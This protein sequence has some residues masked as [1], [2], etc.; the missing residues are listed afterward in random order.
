MSGVEDEHEG[1]HDEGVFGESTRR[2]GRWWVIATVPVVLVAGAFVEGRDA[3][4]F[5]WAIVSGLYTTPGLVVTALLIRRVDRADRL[6]WQLWLAALAWAYG[7][8]LTLQASVLAGVRIPLWW[9]TGAMGVV[10][11][12]F[13]IPLVMMLR[14]RSGGRAI[15]LDV[16]EM[17]MVLT[18]LL[19]PAT[20]LVIE[21]IAETEEAW[22]VVPAALAGT[23][24]FSAFT[25]AIVL[26]VR[27]RPGRR[28]V[29]GL[30]IAAALAGAVTA[31]AN[32]AQGLS[33]FTLPSGPLLALQAIS[34]GLV[35]LVPLHVPRV[36]PQGLDRL[37]P[38]RRARS[39]RFVAVVSL[40][41]LPVLAI[42]MLLLRHD[43]PWAVPY[44]FSLAALLLLLSTL[45]HLLALG[46]T[47]RLYA[48]V[49]RAAQQ[50]RTLLADVMRSAEED[51]HRVAAQLHE[52]AAS[53]Y[54]TFVAFIQAT[55]DDDGP[56]TDDRSAGIR[57]DLLRQTEDLRRLMLAIK[58]L[59][60]NAIGPRN[61]EA[62]LRA[63]LDSLYG[64]ATPPALA[65]DIRGTRPL[66]WITETVLLRIVQ[67]ALQNI[68][69]HARAKHVAVA[70]EAVEGGLRLEVVDDGVGFA[71]ERVLVL[72]GIATM[73]S[74]ASFL[75]GTV[76]IDSAP[77]HG[78]RV[79][80]TLS[81]SS[82]I[83]SS[84]IAPSP[85]GASRMSPT[86]APDL[87]PED[88]VD[89]PGH[90]PHLRVI[91]GGVRDVRPREV[92]HVER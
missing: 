79:T 63:H 87:V 45:R 72:S 51:R 24:L 71:P 41:A 46:E 82:P 6:F 88:A 73:R 9:S 57:H 23:C 3:Y 39:G 29:E 42:E 11:L 33:S 77:G 65:V 74:F 84:P 59:E 22:W 40:V 92:S 52:R 78:T 49:E 31:A 16:V 68:W 60:A 10:I 61:L 18:S 43:I 1:S 67:E 69:S 85:I 4:L 8:G 53:S 83:A 56:S 38:Q 64:D 12:L 15:V 48:E 70:I 32:V 58:P 26:F 27:L 55:R 47:K 2:A 36:S 44:A 76:D 37:P 28:V 7:M 86:P 50:R 13:T 81:A 19:A 17:A 54:A 20:L 25:W 91:A 89:P 90:R 30:G 62:P 21:P 14:A 5:Q 66:D 34:L 75:D 35:L 80:A